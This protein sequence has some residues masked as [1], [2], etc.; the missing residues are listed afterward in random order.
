MGAPT[1]IVGIGGIGGNVV[2]RLADRIKRENLDNVEL[3]IMDTDVNDLRTTKEKYPDIYTVQTSPKGTVGK[4]LDSN[5]HARDKWFPLNDGLTGKP[6]TE[7]AGQVRA[8]SRLAFDYAVEQGHMEELEK[9]IAK[10]HGLSGEAM[11]QEMRVIITGSVAG[12]TGS[13]LVLPVAMYIRNFLIT[14]YQDNS[15]I[16][17]GF[18]LEPDVV[19]GRLSDESERNTQR[20]NAYAAVR[21][22]DAFFRKEY[23]GESDEYSHVVFNAPQP[24]LGDRVDYPNILPY[25]FV[26]LMDA[27]NANGDSLTDADGRYDLEGYKQHAA[28]CIYA[29]ALSAVSARSNSSEDNVIRQLAANNGRSRYCGAGS[30]CLEYPKDDVQRYV[31]LSWA[32]EA[33]SGEWTEIDREYKKAV[34]ENKNLKLSEF[35]CQRF[36][37]LR[38]TSEFYRS[39]AAQAERKNARGEV[40]PVVDEFVASAEG[41][42]RAWA[43]DTLPKN[44]LS[45]KRCLHDEST[46][47]T[48]LSENPEL[49]AEKC[50]D[51]DPEGA[52]Q[53]YLG[54]Y[55]NACRKYA[56]AAREEAQTRS[57]EFA[58]S[59][60]AIS[61]SDD[62]PLASRKYGHLV[63][64]VF[65]E[66]G[67]GGVG[68]YHPAMVRYNL[69]KLHE[70]LEERAAVAETK[71]KQAEK[72]MANAEV[73]DYYSETDD[74]ED[75]AAA[76]SM[77]LSSDKGKGKAKF[78]L[79]ALKKGSVGTAEIDMLVEISQRLNKFKK[80]I[81]AY[82]AETAVHQYL[83]GAKRYVANLIAAYQDFY[84]HIGAEME[85]IKVAIGRIEQNSA[86][87]DPKGISHRYVCASRDCLE[88]IKDEC[89][90]R[91]SSDDLPVE[92]CGDIYRGL[93]RYAKLRENTKDY[94]RRNELSSQQFSGLFQKVIID[95]WTNKVMDTDG[96]ARAVVDKSIIRAIA[97]EGIYTADMA[98][99][100][101]KEKNEYALTYVRRA[102]EGAKKLAT[103]FIEPPVGEHPRKIDI[104]AFSEKAAEGAGAYAD[105]ILGLLRNSYNG[106][107]APAKEFSKYEILFY[108]S[109]YGFCATNLPKYAPAHTGMESRPEGEYHRAY[110]ATINQLSPNLKDNK[111]ITPHIDR[112]WHLVCALPDINP[113]NE[114]V[115]QHNIMHA[116]LHGLV[117]QRFGSESVIDGDDV[118][119]LIASANRART[120]LWVS[121]GTPCD[122]FY[123][124]FDALKFSPPAVERLLESSRDRLA[125][126]KSQTRV[127]LSECDLISYIRSNAFSKQNFDAWG[128]RIQKAIE[129]GSEEYPEFWRAPLNIQGARLASTAVTDL[130]G[131]RLPEGDPRRTS[132]FEI[133]LVYRISLPQSD[134]RESEIN[135]MVESTFRAVKDHLANFCDSGELIH[136]AA[137]LFEE[138]YML[139]EQ[140]LI[141][142]ENEI[143]GINMD[144]VV[145]IV[146]EKVLGYFEAEEALNVRRERV[147]K[148]QKRIDAAWRLRRDNLWN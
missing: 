91:V 99:L 16:I 59:T 47:K 45:L 88:A 1:L 104:C 35:Y 3:V 21:E 137:Q 105:D 72:N 109:M 146:R 40:I 79:P 136:S 54:T 26:F 115:I 38:K 6:F 31:A 84:G 53:S 4:A 17:R 123:E 134:L 87:N 51:G 62:D 78:K 129:G 58:N 22:M 69:Y 56:S 66:Q 103:P 24:G 36:D 50:D 64:S 95:Y 143:Q 34:R 67:E 98:F 39:V 70:L 121:N 65:C 147:R 2:Q 27:L 145:S 74:K 113:D 89:G 86:Y 131:T 138:Q 28:D 11:R 106:T 132:L 43:K 127:S 92:L 75:V 61:D 85:G 18:F 19:F 133:P 124:V 23:A 119:Y 32:N 73:D 68:S 9:A 41:Y 93:L 126:E 144:I 100:D 20:A 117:F 14:R 81:D 48:P 76:I 29:Q 112:N 102:L 108:S 128:E 118:Y 46:L 96:D 55:F 13:G 83:D 33:I 49:I 140:N 107:E 71:A 25:H 122:R 57:M 7:G 135:M 30:S 10:L 101:N 8:V 142:Y 141:G 110:F 44:N 80:E 5:H 12:G 63:E 82:L 60:F 90:K 42:A 125:A 77:I 139:F 37:A 15:A 148:L 97:D 94:K 111:L 114:R 130:F 120:S 116:F 52:M